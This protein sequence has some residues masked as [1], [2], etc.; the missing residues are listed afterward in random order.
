MLKLNVK[1]TPSV[2]ISGQKNGN[3]EVKPQL[4]VKSTLGQFGITA[5]VSR[6]LGIAVGE[7]VMFLNDRDEIQR[8]IVEQNPDVINFA[9]ENGFDLN[10]SIDVNNFLNQ[11]QSWFIAKGYGKFDS[12]GNPLMAN[13]R[14]SRKDK[15]T[16]FEREYN[17]ASDE[18]KESMIASMREVMDNEEATYEDIINAI[19]EDDRVAACITKQTKAYEGSKT[20]STSS[21]VGVGVALTFTD[22]NIWN[23][24]K[25][26][27]DPELRERKKRIFDVDV[28]APVTM[29][30]SNGYEIVE[31]KA[32][33]LTYAEDVDPAT[34][35]RK[36]D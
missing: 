13:I 12:A 20:A 9:T 3:V 22:T 30:C 26:D 11:V 33:P 4:E 8:A 7:N 5:P 17:A 18:E 31:V 23:K 2:V 14:M 27:L 10:N 16:L 15:A 1:F 29:E 35:G 25:V 24:M 32:Y 28:N 19:I 6:A 21:A 34:F 36:E